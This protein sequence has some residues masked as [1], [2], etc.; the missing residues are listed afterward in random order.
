MSMDIRGA[1]AHALQMSLRPNPLP[2]LHDLKITMDNHLDF[3]RLQARLLEDFKEHFG[4]IPTSDPSRLEVQLQ[5]DEMQRQAEED[6][7]HAY[8]GDGAFFN[9][10]IS[11]DESEDAVNDN[12]ANEDPEDD[13]ATVVYNSDDDIAEEAGEEMED[14]AATVDFNE[15]NALAPPVAA[16]AIP[17]GLVECEVCFEHKPSVLYLPCRHLRICQPCSEQARATLSAQGREMECPTCRSIVE[18]EVPCF[19]G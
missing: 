9:Q 11:E 6:E 14:D 15:N 13:A 7:V 16:P 4:H 10:D 18:R 1:G 5:L 8:P 3:G 17:A 19:V 12:Q 2:P